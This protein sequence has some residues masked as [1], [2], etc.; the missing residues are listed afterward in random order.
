M[1]LAVKMVRTGQ[2]RT[3]LKIAATIEAFLDMP[4][5]IILNWRFAKF[6][7]RYSFSLWEERFDRTTC[8]NT[9]SFQVKRKTII[10]CC[11]LKGRLGNP[12]FTFQVVIY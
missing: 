7:I 10:Y 8:L 9:N 11:V 4:K 5:K 3:S 12:G 1:K 2:P 6:R